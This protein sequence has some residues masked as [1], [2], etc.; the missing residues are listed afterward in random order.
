MNTMTID[1]TA[2][3]AAGARLGEGV[4]IG[5]Y[6]TVGPHVVLGEDVNLVGHVHIEGHTTIGARTRIAPFASL[7]TPPQSVKYRGEP[8]RLV[9]GADCDIREHV[10]MNTGTVGDRGITEVGEHCFI[11]VGCHI[12]HD[13]SVGHHVTM[14]N[15]TVLGGHIRVGNYVI[16]GGQ[17]AIHQ[18][19]Q[20]GDYAMIAGVS[21]I[22][23]DVIPFGMAVGQRARLSG[24]NLVGL[25]RR[26][27]PRPDINL[28]RHVYEML[29]LG[30]GHFEERVRAAT[31]Q[32]G[33]NEYVCHILNF[34]AA[35][36]LRPLMPAIA[37]GVI[38]A[39]GNSE[40]SD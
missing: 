36:R 15:N 21:G 7:G 37:G 10:T 32:H 18:F 1:P 19:V 24:L 5:P 23:M 35:K 11:M 33:D 6:C 31:E 9:V 12:A 8:T 20:I 38:K 39:I 30:Q 22:T 28:L 3:I 16:F 27:V 34:I 25:R 17:T 26:R 40:E 4:S 29:F 13:C 14:A 2:R